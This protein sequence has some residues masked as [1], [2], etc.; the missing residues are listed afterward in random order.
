MKRDKSHLFTHEMII[1]IIPHG[2]VVRV[3]REI[4]DGGTQVKFAGSFYFCSLLSNFFFLRS[5][6]LSHYSS[7]FHSIAPKMGKKT[8]QHRGEH[9]CWLGEF[10]TSSKIF[11]NLCSLENSSSLQGGWISSYDGCA[12][13]CPSV[14]HFC[15]KVALPL[16][17][18]CVLKW[19]WEPFLMCFLILGR[20]VQRILVFRPRCAKKWYPENLMNSLRQ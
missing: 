18:R 9:T 7:L 12:T 17:R 14:S 15:N 8:S 3:K 1:I 6:D 16:S 13:G 10:G 5:H 2:V 19:T 4:I 11:L 20:D